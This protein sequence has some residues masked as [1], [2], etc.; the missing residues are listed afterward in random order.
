MYL[1]TYVHKYVLMHIRALECAKQLSHCDCAG[2]GEVMLPVDS[3]GFLLTLACAW[4]IRSRNL[5]P[6]P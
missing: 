5:V 3:P 6:R 1:C 2:P 4:K